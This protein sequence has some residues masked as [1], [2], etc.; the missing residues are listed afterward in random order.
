MRVLITRRPPVVDVSVISKAMSG[1]GVVMTSR[2]PDADSIGELATFGSDD[3][4]LVCSSGASLLVDCGF[5]VVGVVSVCW[6]L[7]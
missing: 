3:S 6:R 7:M 1:L 2:S 4:W 5:C